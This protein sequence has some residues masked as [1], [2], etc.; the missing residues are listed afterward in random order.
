[1][2]LNFVILIISS[3]V[4]SSIS[5]HMKDLKTGESLFQGLVATGIY[6]LKSTTPTFYASTTSSLERHHRLRYPSR[7]VFRQ[8]VSKNKLHVPSIQVTGIMGRKETKLAIFNLFSIKPTKVGSKCQR[9][10][11]TSHTQCHTPYIP[12]YNHH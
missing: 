3:V 4:F 7:D 9:K 6:Q 11:I 12:C 8:I 5:F 2:F 10:L 1:M